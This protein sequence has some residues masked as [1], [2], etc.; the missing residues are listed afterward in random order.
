[1]DLKK[2]SSIKKYN[3]VETKKKKLNGKAINVWLGIRKI[4]DI[5]EE[6]DEPRSALD[7]L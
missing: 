2:Y 4:S 1:M 6:D 3:N 5:D 7:R